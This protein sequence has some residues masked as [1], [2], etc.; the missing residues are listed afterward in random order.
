MGYELG[1][2]AHRTEDR[3]TSAWASYGEWNGRFLLAS[4]VGWAALA[5]SSAQH[6]L[7]SRAAPLMAGIPAVFAWGTRGLRLWGLA[8][9]REGGLARS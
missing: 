8:Q 7:L 2:L 5:A 4:G 6:D 1:D 3:I 9:R